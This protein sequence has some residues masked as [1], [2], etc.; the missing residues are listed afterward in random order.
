[1]ITITDYYEKF[2]S[3]IA[4]SSK[5]IHG[6]SGLPLECCYIGELE[7]A[8]GHKLPAMFSF[9]DYGNLIFLSRHSNREFINRN[10]ESLVL[11]LMATLPPNMFRFTLYD[12][13]GLGS[14]LISL[15]KVNSRIL[16]RKEIITDPDEFK[17]ALKEIQ[18]HI[19]NVIQ[20]VLSLKYHDKTLYDF[21]SL[22]KDKAVPYQFIV[23]TDLPHTLGK[24][25]CDILETIVKNGRK[26]GIFVIMSVDAES[27]EET[28]Y[29]SKIL[30]NL[31][32]NSTV[33]Y[34]Q[35]GRYYI[36]NICIESIWNKFALSLRPDFI[37]DVESVLYH[38]NQKEDT[39]KPVLMINLEDYLPNE[40]F[41]WRKES[42]HGIS[43]P[44]GVTP[45][46]ETVCLNIT[47]T[48]GQNVAVVVGIPG[49]GKSVFLNSVITSC[50]V[51]YSP[52]ELEMYL[53]DFS[54]VE[55]NIYAD[56]MLPHAKVIAPES[57][58]EFGISILR[59]IKEEGNRRMELFR[60]AGVNDITNYKKGNPNERFPRIL[61]I[62]DEFQKFFEDDFDNMTAEAESILRI[63]VQEY[64][65]FGI[66]LILATQSISK[67]V[68]KIELGMIANRVAFE[69]KAD[70]AHFIFNN[71]PPVNMISEPGDCVYN[72]KSGK[73]NGNIGAKSFYV[74]QKQLA[75][76]LS[77]IGAFAREKKL[78][79]EDKI[80]FRSDAPALFERNPRLGS[81]KKEDS[82][83]KVKVY[84][85]EAIAISEDVHI[86]LERGTSSNI[87]VVGGQNS[88]AA[89][90]VAVNCVKSLVLAHSDNKANFLFFN[91][92]P[93]ED[94][95]SS[96]PEELYGNIPFFHEFVDVD[97]QEECL[98]KIKA[99]IERRQKDSMVRKRHVYLSF[100]NF[101][102]AHNFNKQN[103]WDLSGVAQLLSFILDQGP[104]FGVFTIL[105]VDELSSL[106]KFLDRGILDKFNHRIA[107]QM[108]ENDSLS[109][110]EDKTASKLYVEN[111]PS[112]KNRAY[113]F[114]KNNNTKTKFKPYNF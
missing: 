26:A 4:N 67:Y 72:D 96:K 57:E 70:D 22:E 3:N 46:T 99:E 1:M 90:R 78:S 73:P 60:N 68:N 38:I 28:T 61:I 97:S 19:P 113:Y 39:D 15:S 9:A 16:N 52:D 23:I 82:P 109:V 71:V 105:Q 83:K 111:K 98:T 13:M 18:A 44:F 31:L 27:D 76:I 5:F 112:S 94:V 101:Q 50:A 54:G 55:F 33:I 93:E 95:N 7:G 59:K 91:Y 56:S 65:K 6:E 35:N 87:L 36:K 100:Y 102:F 32:A 110:I 114:N 74:S 40:R 43:V 69:W 24:E 41:W 49:S 84:L 86:E 103:E 80:I 106:V 64:R 21:N 17:K 45:Q 77:R 75:D 11:R 51:H 30:S 89:I 53:I 66:N 42:S 104:L 8:S 88:D 107:L 34:E 2:G 48:S 20:K 47:Q 108:S 25:H 29:G 10:I 58:R 63:I 37:D 85:G 92:M 14:N 81:I 62:I 12:G 79:V